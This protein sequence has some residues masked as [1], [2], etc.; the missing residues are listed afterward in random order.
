M[1]VQKDDGVECLGLGRC[2]DPTLGG[3]MIKKGFDLPGA[4]FGRMAFAVKEDEVPDP[5]AIG[6]LGLGAEMAPATDDGELVEQARGGGD[7][8]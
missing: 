2:C 6:G 7:T 4:H 8:P 1:V 3:Q 5:I